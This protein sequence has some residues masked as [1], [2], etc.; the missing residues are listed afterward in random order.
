[1]TGVQTCALPISL[2][3]PVK[4]NNSD[5]TLTESV[6]IIKEL[7]L[8]GN[9]ELKKATNKVNLSY[10]NGQTMLSVKCQYGIPLEFEMI[11][12]ET[13]TENIQI[14]TP[15]IFSLEN[16]LVV[17]GDTKSVNIFDVTGRMVVNK[18][19]QS[20]KKRFYLTK[21]KLYLIIAMLSDDSLFS[22]KYIL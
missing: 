14:D 22:F 13:S 16:Q 9:W 5:N 15:N 4:T 8:E 2:R 1:M 12:L 6:Q 21:N 3:R 18:D 7:V 19:F 20:D 11:K 17:E 10:N